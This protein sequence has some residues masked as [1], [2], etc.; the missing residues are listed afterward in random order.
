[1]SAEQPPIQKVANQRSNEV[2]PA[3]GQSRH[4]F[5]TLFL[6]LSGSFS[7][8]SCPYELGFSI[9]DQDIYLEDIPIRLNLND[10]LPLTLDPEAY[11]RKLADTLFKSNAKEYFN[12][13][14]RESK[15]QDHRLRV[16]LRIDPI[17]LQSVYWE[18]LRYPSLTGLLP[19]SAIPFSRFLPTKVIP[20][21][22]TVLEYP[23]RFLVVIASPVDLDRFNLNHLGRSEYQIL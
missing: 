22:H 7:R 21:Q 13:L 6:R 14:V 11:G 16:R 20:A 1:M 3:T 23:L 8:E 12:Q 2:A 17:E 4:K 5:L 9:P 18:S 10:L 15:S 19:P